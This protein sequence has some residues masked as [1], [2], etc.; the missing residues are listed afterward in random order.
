[1]VSGKHY[2]KESLVNRIKS[3]LENDAET[4]CWE[5]QGTTTK[6]G[7]GMIAAD[8]ENFY[9]HRVMQQEF[10]KN[11]TEQEPF[12]CHTCD[13]PR[14]V[15]PDHLFRGSH[16]DNMDDAAEKGRMNGPNY[17]GDDHHQAKL[18]SAQ[19]QS[20]REDYA[21]GEIYAERISR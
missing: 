10:N 7:Y 14:C 2:S 16:R 17:E 19:V 15:N 5:W 20:L 8:G 3:N 13:N 11:L 18:N 9:T 1:M 4:G 12:V 21:S 6:A